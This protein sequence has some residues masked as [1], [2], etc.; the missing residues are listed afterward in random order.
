MK[1][2]TNEN[3]YCRIFEPRTSG[4]PLKLIKA[5]HEIGVIDKSYRGGNGRHITCFVG[6]GKAIVDGVVLLF[7]GEGPN[8]N[9]RQ[10]FSDGFL[11]VRIKKINEVSPES[12]ALIKWITS[13][14]RDR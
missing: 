10:I 9:A 5:A 11:E 13:E 4:T 1:K 6:E 12:E 14:S 7:K 3:K 2:I 8:G